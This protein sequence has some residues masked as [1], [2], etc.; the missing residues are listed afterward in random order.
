MVF[1][2]KSKQPKRKP[3]AAAAAEKPAKKP[4]PG[5]KKGSKKQQKVERFF[6]MEPKRPRPMHATQNRRNLNSILG[7]LASAVRASAEEPAEGHEEAL[8]QLGEAQLAQ[9]QQLDSL[10]QDVRELA[11]AVRAL[12][13]QLA[14][15]PVALRRC[16][17][18]HCAHVLPS[19]L[20]LCLEF[21]GSCLCGFLCDLLV[22]RLRPLLQSPAP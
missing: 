18:V 13:R 14:P 4:K 5:S 15:S 8:E 10:R 9:Q 6:T 19:P 16:C 22:F 21:T 17:L 3:V 2:P 12:T 20:T 7:D 1:Q 11:N